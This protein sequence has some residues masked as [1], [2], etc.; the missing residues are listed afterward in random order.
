MKV[1]ALLSFEKSVAALT[2]E[3]KRR[4]AHGLEAF[5]SFLVDRHASHGFGLKKIGP[6]HYEFRVG[7]RIRVLLKFQEDIYWLVLA[8]NHDEIKK[9]LK[10]A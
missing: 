9:Y 8:G 1:I 10:R 2:S 4:V 3:E 5:N 7:L 6:H